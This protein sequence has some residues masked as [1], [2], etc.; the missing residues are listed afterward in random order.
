MHRRAVITIDWVGP[1]K[2]VRALIEDAVDGLFM[3]DDFMT[4]V[5]FASSDLEF[6]PRVKETTR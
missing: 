2:R 5:G 6:T 3:N 1:D 4:A